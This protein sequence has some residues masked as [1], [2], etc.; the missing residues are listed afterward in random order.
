MDAATPPTILNLS[1]QWGAT[2]QSHEYKVVPS[3]KRGMRAKGARRAEDRFARAIESEMNRLAAE[4][5][6]F[7]RSDTLPHEHKAGWFRRPVTLFQTV[8]VFRRAKGAEAAHGVPRTPSAAMPPPVALPYAEA[9]STP[10]LVA[11]ATT[12]PPPPSVAAPA[13]SRFTPPPLAPKPAND[14]APV[15]MPPPAPSLSLVEAP[16]DTEAPPP[17]SGP[18]PR[19]AAE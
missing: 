8:L 3:P 7:V 5:W 6:E 9:P 11:P 2:M 10:S 19:H 16:E 18:N 4:G 15:A 12:V 1:D 17:P 13:A 14:L